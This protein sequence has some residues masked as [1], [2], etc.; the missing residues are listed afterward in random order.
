LADWFN[1]KWQHVFRTLF[2]FASIY[3][4]WPWWLNRLCQIWVILCQFLTS[5]KKHWKK[6]IGRFDII[7][8]KLASRPIVPLSGTICSTMTPLALTTINK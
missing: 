2:S 5:Q 8:A 7:I 6:H 4:L 1:N 3:L